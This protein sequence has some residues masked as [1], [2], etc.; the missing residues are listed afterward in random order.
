MKFFKI[1]FIVFILS[2]SSFLSVHKFY[3]SI[4]QIEYVKEK[5]SI[6]FITQIFIEDLE[7]LLQNRHDKNIILNKLKTEKN[8]DLYIEDY[9]SKKIQVK[10]NNKQVTFNF[11]GKEYKDD[12][13]LCYLEITNI[14][15]IR[16]FEIKNTLFFEIFREQQNVIK[17]N[18]NS[19]KHSFVLTEQN[20]EA[21][22]NF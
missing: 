13:V 20:Y 18:I 19:R 17:T 3:V 5:E 12:L 15:F 7:K 22:I 8:I 4:T 10:V 9:I 11:I 21:D 6:Q 16:D 2:L 14:S 1:F